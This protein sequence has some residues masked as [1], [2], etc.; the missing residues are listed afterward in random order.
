MKRFFLVSFLSA[1]T[2]LG[3]WWGF[4]QTRGPHPSSAT[5]TALLPKGTLGLLYVPDFKKSRAQWH[6]TD[7][8]K[9]WSEPAL[10]DFLSKP[11]ARSPETAG[12]R[13]MMQ[14]MDALEI[15]D[16]FLAVTALENRRPSVIGGF[17]FKG[18][19]AEA[20]AVIGPW[21]ARL[22]ESLPEAKRE[23]VTYEGHQVEMLGHDAMT[24]ATAYDGEWFFVSNDVTSLKTVLDRV[25]KRATEKATT[26]TADEDFVAV[27]SHMP[28]DYAVF[29]YV[30]LADYMKTLAAKLPPATEGNHAEAEALQQIRSVALATTFTEGKIRDTLFVAMPKHGENGDLTRGSLALATKESFLYLASMLNLPPEFSLPDGASAAT[31]ALPPV[32]GRFLAAG[33][34]SGITRADW[35]ES[36]GNELGVIGEW[37]AKSRLPSLFATL[38][39]KDVAKAKRIVEA[40]TNAAPEGGGWTESEKDG[41]QYFAQP[42]PNPMV[43]LAPTIGLSPKLLVAGLDTGSVERA[44]ERG[45]SSKSELAN[46]EIYKKAEGLVGAPKQSFTYLDTALF[47]QRLDAALRPMLIMAAAF[48]PSVAEKVDLGKLPAPEVITAHLSPLVISQSYSGSGYRVESVGPIS[49]FQAALGG[50]VASGA[51]FEFYQKQMQSRAPTPAAT[52]PGGAGPVPSSIPPDATP[53]LPSPSESPI[54]DATAGI[55][56]ADG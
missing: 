37:P 39:V 51:G 26:L 49:I 6:E 40:L 14:E 8:Y 3:I 5:V 29:G 43:P 28:S 46:A 10:Q 44:I 56:P 55:P 16:A 21:R 23:M 15:K 33:A 11:I 35:T 45:Q 32:L 27:A 36:F 19:Q 20:E 18:S 54:P 2:A 53:G 12:T 47:Y 1:M 22:Q 34:A 17:R 41:V 52:P 4:Y 30:R 25:D 31:N 13:R 38:A 24:A 7:L 9:L 42:P 50:I 48:M